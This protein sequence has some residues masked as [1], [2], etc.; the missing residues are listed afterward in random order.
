MGILEMWIAAENS[1]DL[2]HH[3]KDCDVDVLGAV[4][5]SAYN[6]GHLA[7]YRI[8]YLHDYKSYHEALDQFVWWTRKSLIRRRVKLRPQELG[9]RILVGW[10][11]DICESCQGRAYE[12][13]P[14]DS[15]RLDA[16]PFKVC[17]GTGK[18]RVVCE[19]REVHTVQD[20]IEQAN[21]LVDSLSVRVSRNLGVK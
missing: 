16:K 20:V 21:Q 12:I 2:Q 10:L 6:N 18:K 11:D 4:G 19:K 7:V 9:E 13:T 1:S 5:F 8:K 3:E 14:G 17:G 15:P